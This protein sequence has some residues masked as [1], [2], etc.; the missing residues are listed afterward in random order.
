MGP[1]ANKNFA[2]SDD[3]RIHMTN[4]NIIQTRQTESKTHN[5]VHWLTMKPRVAEIHNQPSEKVS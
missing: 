1:N 5:P 4:F 2:T 3:I